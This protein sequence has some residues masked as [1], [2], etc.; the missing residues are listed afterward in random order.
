M[1]SSINF[2]EPALL[3]EIIHQVGQTALMKLS[4]AKEEDFEVPADL[5]PFRLPNLFHSFAKRLAHQRLAQKHPNLP[6]IRFVVAD[7]SKTPNREQRLANEEWAR[8]ASDFSVVPV[9]QKKTKKRITLRKSV[10]LVRANRAFDRG[11]I[12]GSFMGSSPSPSP[13]TRPSARGSQLSRT[14]DSKLRRASSSIAGSGPLIQSHSSA[15]TTLRSIEPLTEDDGVVG[16]ECPT[17]IRMHS[18]ASASGSA[19]SRTKTSPPFGHRHSSVTIDQYGVPPLSS[20]MPRM[21]IAQSQASIRV[22]KPKLVDFTKPAPDKP[23]L[24]AERRAQ[25][26]EVESI[27]ETF[28]KHDQT[29]SRRA[30]TKALLRPQDVLMEASQVSASVL[31]TLNT[32]FVPTSAL[33]RRMTSRDSSSAASITNIVTPDALMRRR[34][35]ISQTSSAD[36]SSVAPPSAVQQRR[37]SMVIQ[38]EKIADGVPPVMGRLPTVQEHLTSSAVG[39]S[40]LRQGALKMSKLVVKPSESEERSS[41][42]PALNKPGRPKTNCWWSVGEYKD[43][44]KRHPAWAKEI[45]RQK[46]EAKRQLAI[47]PPAFRSVM[48]PKARLSTPDTAH[49]STKYVRPSPSIDQF[50]IEPQSLKEHVE[51]TQSSAQGKDFFRTQGHWTTPACVPAPPTQRPTSSKS[52]FD[53]RTYKV[54]HTPKKQEFNTVSSFEQKRQRSLSSGQTPLPFAGPSLMT[55]L[56]ASH[57]SLK[58]VSESSSGYYQQSLFKARPS[59]LD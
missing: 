26:K 15:N 50:P 52:L 38:L 12:R 42:D 54:Y 35:S 25:L 37:L 31:E 59:M 19:R 56:L 58:S 34:Q 13:S 16:E 10:M 11:S 48:S 1:S 20:L 9:P 2:K 29:V 40:P 4:D 3:A 33:G 44:R 46:E 39:A 36:S 55:S 28:A 45:K 22:P 17:L 32:R 23:I 18:R 57:A 49:S 30:L 8:K 43:L 21:S 51:Q 5:E 47:G 53:H 7:Y 41:S 24:T 6:P 27:M 14:A